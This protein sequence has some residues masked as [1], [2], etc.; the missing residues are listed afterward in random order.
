M[1]LGIPDTQVHN[2]PARFLIEAFDDTNLFVQLHIAPA[3]TGH[4]R[5]VWTQRWFHIAME[6]GF[7]SKMVI[8]NGYAKITRG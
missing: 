1:P 7:F 6:I 4:P 2:V 8:L 3:G 5:Y